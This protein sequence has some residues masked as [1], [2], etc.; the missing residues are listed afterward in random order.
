MLVPRLQPQP[1]ADTFRSTIAPTAVGPTTLAPR[2]RMLVPRLQ[3][4]PNSEPFRSTVAS[5]TTAAPTPLTLKHHVLASKPV[6]AIRPSLTSTFHKKRENPSSSAN[7]PVRLRAEKRRVAEDARAFANPSICPRVK[8]RRV[9]EDAR[10]SEAVRLA[11]GLLEEE[12]KARE[13]AS[14]EFPPDIS[15]S[16]IRTSIRGC[17]VALH[18]LTVD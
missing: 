3:T 9:V 11:V 18:R 8:K 5:T 2:H 7:P 4:Q 1:N 12:F 17:S 14:R 10:A 15:S 16:H 13:T 6:A